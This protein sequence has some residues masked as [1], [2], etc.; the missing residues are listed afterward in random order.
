MTPEQIDTVTNG[1][2]NTYTF[3][4]EHWA[5]A[6]YLACTAAVWWALARIQRRR[7]ARRD[8]Q[9]AIRRIEQYAN[10]PGARRL[11]D[12]THRQPREDEL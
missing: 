3:I 10:H 7:R 5:H 6:A 1:L 2:I 9:Q 11:H 4:D 8:L 12:D